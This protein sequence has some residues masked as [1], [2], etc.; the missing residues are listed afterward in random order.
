MKPE[1]GTELEPKLN[2]KSEP[3]LELEPELEP[4]MRSPTAELQ[5]V[6]LDGTSD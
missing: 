4:G 2:L 5:L 6:E 3:E 1:S